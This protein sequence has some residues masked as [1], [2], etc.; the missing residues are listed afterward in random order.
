MLDRAYAMKTRSGNATLPLAVMLLA[1][2]LA[3]C[4][5]DDPSGPGNFPDVRGEWV[6]QYRVLACTQL[7]GSDPLF[8]EGIFYVG[9]SLSL[10][11][12]LSQSSSRVNGLALQGS[13]EGQVDGSIDESGVLAL[14]GQIGVGDY[15][16]TTIEEWETQ[17][18]GDSL[19]GS[20]VFEVED[21]TASDY[22]IA[23]VEAD[24]T[25]IDPSVPNYLG[26]PVE[27]DLAHTDEI[28]GA[29]GT[30]DCQLDDESYYDVFS[31]DVVTGDQVEFRMGSLHF[32]PALLIVD[33]EGWLLHCSL[34]EAWADC[35]RNSPDSIATFALEAVVDE[36]WLVIANALGR[37]DVGDYSL[38]TQA[39]GGASSTAGFR[40]QAIPYDARYGIAVDSSGDVLPVAEST[41]EALLRK[42]TSQSRGSW[43]VKLG[44]SGQNR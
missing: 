38:T 10:G 13:I 34:P 6:G 42:F 25:L 5:G 28:L 41:R 35:D 3:G 18:V 37:P 26:C 8:C 14:S 15:A 1:V 19:V 27:G 39:L 2:L 17:L 16:T 40:L 4:G 12:T 31:V 21:N 24:V 30:D 29:L 43:S 22:G 44:K 7:S 9:R 32:K 36:T 11:L 23:R 33:L 20:W